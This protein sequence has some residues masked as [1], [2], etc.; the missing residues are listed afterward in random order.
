MKALPSV[1]CAVLLLAVSGCGP[2]RDEVRAREA[3]RLR[4]EQDAQA[5]AQKANAAI[6]EMNRKLGRKPPAMN[7]GTGT[8]TIAPAKPQP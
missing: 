3:E 8:R 4:L 2:S 5:A 1:A 7:L 6:T